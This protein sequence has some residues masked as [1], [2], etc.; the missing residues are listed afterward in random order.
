MLVSDGKGVDDDD[1]DEEEDD[2]DDDD[3]DT[4]FCKLHINSL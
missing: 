3:D 1:D 4:V 2:D